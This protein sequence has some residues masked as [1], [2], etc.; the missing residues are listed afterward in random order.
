[1]MKLAAAYLAS[2]VA[3]TALLA[4]SASAQQTDW[5][6][7]VT[8]SSMGGHVLGNPLAENR[9]VEYVSY[10]CNHCATF[11]TTSKGPIK[12]GYIARG[13]V[14]T[15]VRNYVRDA[16]D[17][18]A[19]LLARCGGRTKFFSNHNLLMSSQENWLKTVQSTAPEVQ[20]TWN[21][22]DINAR[23]KKIAADV[24]FYDIIAKRDISK[25]QANICLA[26]KDAQE[27]ILAMTTYGAETV[28]ITGTPS[29]T[30]NDK[31]LDKVH[32]W[33]VLKPVL[34]ALPTNN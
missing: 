2:A 31:L 27:K 4:V 23:L 22:G 33:P 15:E 34:A 25:A 14:N 21:E 1:M 19:A 3:A 20:K 10:T 18:T 32:S 5:T 28:K 11:E 13:H 7:R 16:V 30:M 6:K 8:V 24:G 9:L 17:F 12:S 29:F 26:D